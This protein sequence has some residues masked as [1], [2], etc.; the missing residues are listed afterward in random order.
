MV[1]RLLALYTLICASAA[2]Q[3]TAHG[4]LMAVLE[5]NTKLE[6]AQKKA[7]DVQYLA[8]T[9][10]AA[11]LDVVPDIRVMTRENEM[12]LLEQSGKKLSE[13]E[14]ECE[15]D[16]GRRLGADYVVSGDVLRF[17]SNLKVN[18]KLHETAEGSLLSS[19]EASGKDADALDQRLGPAVDKLLA[20]LKERL[21]AAAP[22]PAPAE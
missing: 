12:V 13:C 5:F 2:A 3:E 1:I 18:L 17:G 20:P 10:R 9:V 14:G 15:V 21:S 22:S 4:K 6:G 7:V 19:K 8:D 11:V 16:T